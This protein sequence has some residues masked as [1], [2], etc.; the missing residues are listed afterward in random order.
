MLAYLVSIRAQLDVDGNGQEEALADAVIIQRYMTGMRGNP[1][2]TGALGA[3][4]TRT[5]PQIEAYLKTLTP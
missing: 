1:M 5:T 3:G 4:A 2:T